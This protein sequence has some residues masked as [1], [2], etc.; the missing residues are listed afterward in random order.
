MNKL[1]LQNQ[2]ICNRLKHL[3]AVLRKH[4]LIIVNGYNNYLFFTTFLFNLFSKKKKYI[5]TESDTQFATPKNPIIRFIKWIYLNFV[6]R[7]K[8][9]L[10]FAGG[11]F[12]HKKL[13]RNYG[14]E[15]RRIFLM[16]MM[17]DN[18]KFYQKEKRF[19]T[20]FTFLYVGRLVKHKNVEGIIRQFNRF[21][22]DKNV[23]L[24]IVGSGNEEDRL[25]RKYASDKVLFL[26]KK[27]DAELIK[28]FQNASCF[29]CPSLFEPWG[30]VVNEAMSSGLPV[31]VSKNVG[32]SFDLIKDKE[33]GFVAEDINGFGTKMLDL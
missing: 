10:G 3:I 32:A 1:C 27:V 8:Y 5:A 22:S 14:M 11:N 31:I 33:T 17:V 20:I 25:R 12:T 2:S 6:F 16:P 29:L 13:F 21:F 19:P 24:R 28:E 26:G 4:D 7:N 15:E 18:A 23:M 30:L 9:V